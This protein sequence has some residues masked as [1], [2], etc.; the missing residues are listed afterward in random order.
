[1]RELA[2]AAS[3]GAAVVAAVFLPFV[4]LAPD[5]LWRSLH[6][7]LARPLQVE[8]LGASLLTTFG[9]PKVISTHGSL[10]LAGQGAAAAATTAVELV[11][12]AVLWVAFANGPAARER[13]VRYFAASVCA[14]IAF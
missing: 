6:G 5:G 8:S 11:V 12:L 9:H 1:A 13:L 10:N 2:W 4:L 14:F 3:A 7:Q